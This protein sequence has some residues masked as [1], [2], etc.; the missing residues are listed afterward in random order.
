MDHHLLTFTSI[1]LNNLQFIPF[2]LWIF[3]RLKFHGKSF[4]ASSVSESRP[5]MYSFL[6]QCFNDRFIDKRTVIPISEKLNKIECRDGKECQIC[7]SST[8]LFTDATL[9]PKTNQSDYL[10]RNWSPVVIV[11]D[12]VLQFPSVPITLSCMTCHFLEDV[13]NQLT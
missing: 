2:V 3:V 1:L 10:I 8:I 13:S 12:N 11:I 9:M 6:V 4:S 7:N 5:L